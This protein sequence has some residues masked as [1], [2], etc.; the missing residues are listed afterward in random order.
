MLLYD[1]IKRGAEEYP[2]RTAI[3]FRVGHISYGELAAQVNLAASALR[4]RGIA[5]GSRVALLLPNCPPFTISYFAAAAIGAVCVPANP[6]LKPAELSHMWGD[7]GI[8]S[9]I[10]APPLLAHAQEALTDRGVNALLVSIGSRDD[11]PAPILTF[12]E[13][14]ADGS[15]DEASQLGIDPSDPAVCIYTSGTTG[16][17][18][19]ALLSHKNLLTNC[20][21]IS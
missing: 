11:T 15:A 4:A 18:K 2:D 14:L 17:P 7:A 10:T 9:V 16:R 19:G 8:E 5:R 13:L 6:L 3:I 21:Q 12:E 20:R 1:I